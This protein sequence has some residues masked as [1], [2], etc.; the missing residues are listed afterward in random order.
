MGNFTDEGS[1]PV[2]N[3]SS[4]KETKD[5]LNNSQ[6]NVSSRIVIDNPELPINVASKKII[7]LFNHVDII[8]WLLS[9]SWL[10]T[11]MAGF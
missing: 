5:T 7:I 1:L 8:I 4:T 6:T 3:S 11:I 10:Q 2:G 9:S